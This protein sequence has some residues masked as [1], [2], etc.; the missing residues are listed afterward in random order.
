VRLATQTEAKLRRSAHSEAV[1]LFTVANQQFTIAADAVQEIRSTDSLS[2]A[3]N[4]LDQSDVPKVRHTVERSHRRYYVVNAGAHFGLPVTRPSL[5]LIL[6]ELRVA[7][8]VDRIER[9]TEIARV[10][11][12]PQAFTGKERGWYR[13]L[14]Y[15]DSS[16]VPV[17]RPSG[18][19]TP[20]DFVRLDA[21]SEAAA[22][23]QDLQGMVQA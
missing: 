5:V 23:H 13:G 4:D 20:E 14:A 18:F 2:G 22:A 12:L 16:V 7:V 10:Y 3:A 9:M 17:I 8:L 6:R 1:I 15:L 11:P 19:L 21:A